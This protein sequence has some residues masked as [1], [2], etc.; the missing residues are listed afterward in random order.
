M[1][2]AVIS[3]FQKRTFRNWIFSILIFMTIGF[4]YFFVNRQPIILLF[5]CLAWSSQTVPYK[6]L[7]KADFWSR[8][9]VA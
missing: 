4:G 1:L 6:K 9:L 7:V 8:L 5:L 3:L 2:L